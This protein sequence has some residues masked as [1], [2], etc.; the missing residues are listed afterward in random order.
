VIWRGMTQRLGAILLKESLQILR[1]PS[2]FG[3]AVVLPLL[4]L[5]V[6]GYGISLDTRG[7][8][9]GLSVEDSSP[10]A[11]DLAGAFH[12]SRWF[13]VVDGHNLDGFKASLVAGDVRGIIIIPAQFE[14]K[15]AQGGASAIQVITDGSSPNTAAFLAGH[16]RG[17]V[18]EWALQR[19]AERGENAQQPISVIP[20]FA[21]N[22][23]LESRY[24]L[25]PGAIA[26]V[27]TMIGTMLTALVIAREYE[28]GTM[29]GLMAT[30]LG[31]VEL[32]ISK[33]V[34]YYFLGLGSMVLCTTVAVTM[35]GLPFHGSVIALFIIASAFLFPALGQGLLISA[36]TRN[37][38]VSTQIALLSGW[39]PSL[40]L[41]GFLFE[42]DSMPR[43]IQWLTY[44]VPARYL[45]P[46][47]ET[48]F[49]IG[50]LWSLF[51]PNIAIMLLFGSV[52]FFLSWR[53]TSRTIA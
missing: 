17:L 53:A 11:R 36:A 49:L 39:L 18:A 27:M 33:I 25:V 20:R 34:P 21:Y 46:P 32:I 47:L 50:D 51:L 5:F 9:V 4:L 37:Q 23:G 44:L 1:D 35:F 10:V 43:P 24:F 7:T 19:A 22:P 12:H 14:Q 3:M 30:P 6:F 26:I 40:L 13:T 28:R 52:F 15:L 41:S 29:E 48:V 42:I 31:V 8:K 38:F 45:I 2:T 16:A